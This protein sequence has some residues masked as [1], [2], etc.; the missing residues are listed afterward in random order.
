MFTSDNLVESVRSIFAQL[1][2]CVEVELRSAVERKE[3]QSL[4]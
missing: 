2:E 3:R 4:R 1:I